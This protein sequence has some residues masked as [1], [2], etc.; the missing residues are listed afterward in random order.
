MK[1]GGRVYVQIRVLLALFRLVLCVTWDKEERTLAATL[2]KF[3]LHQVAIACCSVLLVAFLGAGTPDFV[4][5]QSAI[6]AAS[7]QAIPTAVPQ[8]Q[9][10]GQD[11]GP[12]QLQAVA[13]FLQ[14]LAAGFIA[15]L[16]FGLKAATEK[17]AQAAEKQLN[18][19]IG[20]TKSAQQQLAQSIR[21]VEASFAQVNVA[22]EQVAVSSKQIDEMI[23]QREAQFQPY[24]TVSAVSVDDQDSP[25]PYKMIASAAL[26]NIGKGPALSVRGHLQYP[27]LHFEP[28]GYIDSWQNPRFPQ[29]VIVQGHAP[30]RLA[31]DD[32]TL[33]LCFLASPTSS[34]SGELGGR[35]LLTIEY[36]DLMGTWWATT[37]PLRLAG[38][39]SAPYDNLE[40]VV[41]DQ[42]E[43]VGRIEG[44]R[45]HP[46]RLEPDAPLLQPP[47]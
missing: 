27:R 25:P 31:A 24:V 11:S 2:R 22:T 42:E 47:D 40:F 20:L 43:L 37:T 5:A 45:I 33:E 29:R 9:A 18:E 6:P 19:S 34:V 14:F 10:S 8:Q 21:Q 7:Q 39:T 1:R 44:P 13:A 46:D 4:S 30:Q 38:E 32:N 28:Y 41:G 15:Y 23:R 16:T 17:Y 12:A 26:V 3:W 35:A 36:R